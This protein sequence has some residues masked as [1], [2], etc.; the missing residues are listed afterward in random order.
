[1]TSAEPRPTSAELA[2]ATATAGRC[3]MAA[4]T[5]SPVRGATDLTTSGDGLAAVDAVLPPPGEAAEDA[6]V[7]AGTAECF[8]FPEHPAKATITAH[9]NAVH[10]HRAPAS[11]LIA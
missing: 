3:A 5:V 11:L 6:L 7:P 8:A 4:V 9:D 1:M 10:T 2:T